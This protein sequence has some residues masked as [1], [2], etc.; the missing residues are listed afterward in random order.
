MALRLHPRAEWEGRQRN[1][2]CS[3]MLASNGRAVAVKT[4]EIWQ[5]EHERIF[6]VP[7]DSRGY[8]R[9]DDVRQVMV[10][11]ARIRPHE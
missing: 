8:G 9:E 2:G 4:A 1:A 6:P 5:T 7:A 11:I 10:C 3:P